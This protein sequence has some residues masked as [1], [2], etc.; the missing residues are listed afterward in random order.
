MV[1]VHVDDMGLEVLFEAVLAVGTTDSRLAPPSVKTLHGLKILAIDVG[2]SKF[3]L[4]RNPHG[5]MRL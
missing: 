3:Q 2:F 1:V 4:I 5:H